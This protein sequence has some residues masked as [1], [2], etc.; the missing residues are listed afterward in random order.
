[1]QMSIR[2]LTAIY[3]SEGCTLSPHPHVDLMS[4][5]FIS[6]M[7]ISRRY[8][9]F[10]RT[11]LTQQIVVWQA[12]RFQRSMLYV[13]ASRNEKLLCQE[14]MVLLLR[15]KNQKIQT[16]TLKKHRPTKKVFV[17]NASPSFSEKISSWLSE[18]AFFFSLS[19]SELFPAQKTTKSRNET[20]EETFNVFINH[21]GVQQTKSILLYSTW[22]RNDTV[23]QRHRWSWCRR[24]P[25]W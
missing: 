17:P 9:D 7:S 23:S 25:R 21:A 11:T 19:V 15:N 14:R 8:S 5:F 10:W 18:S 24:S 2:Y 6:K 20:W 3:S 12:G 16:T 4:N 22:T 1:M 13:K